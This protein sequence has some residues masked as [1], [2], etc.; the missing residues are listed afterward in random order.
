[1]TSEMLIK[2]S[3]GGLVDRQ[4]T[5]VCS[6]CC[7]ARRV[8]TGRK[9]DRKWRLRL[10][11]LLGA[12]KTLLSYYQKKK[13]KDVKWS[14]NALTKP[15][16]QAWLLSTEKI[17]MYNQRRH[18]LGKVGGFLFCETIGA[19]VFYFKIAQLILRATELFISITP[20]ITFNIMN[21]VWSLIV[22]L[23]L[24]GPIIWNVL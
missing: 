19:F 6:V 20:Y 2:H 16:I 13:K 21:E 15:V 12:E 5:G 4:T 17:S 24:I 8:Q 14:D 3:F 10:Y 11:F 7:C 23:L 18:A 1:M 9:S 22:L